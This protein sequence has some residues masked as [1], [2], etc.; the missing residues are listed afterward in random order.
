MRCELGLA[1]RRHDE[2]EEVVLRLHV[3]GLA[4]DPVEE[5][6]Q[7]AARAGERVDRDGQVV[8]E[9]VEEDRDEAGAA[10][11]VVRD[12]RAADVG[13]VGHRLN[14]Q[15]LEAALGQHA[16]RR[17]EDG[18]RRGRQR[19]HGV[20]ARQARR[21]LARPRQPRPPSLALLFRWSIFLA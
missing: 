7:A 1:Q 11:E 17:L 6:G 20:V 14:G 3:V 2:L 12:Q 9:R 4:L 18:A 15:T 8:E 5:C 13:F 16:A 19:V 21:V 10:A